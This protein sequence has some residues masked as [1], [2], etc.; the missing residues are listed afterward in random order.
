[1]LRNWKE[2]VVFVKVCLVPFPEEKKK[3]TFQDNFVV[4][5]NRLFDVYQSISVKEAAAA[6]VP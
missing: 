4:L 2:K 5:K 6:H 1:M 3:E